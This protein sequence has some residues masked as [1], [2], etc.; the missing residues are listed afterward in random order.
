MISALSEV[1][2]CLR[3]RSTPLDPDEAKERSSELLD[4]AERCA[5]FVLGELRGKDGSLLRSWREGRATIGAYLED[6]AYLLEALL[7]LYE[8]TFKERWFVEA[9]Q[10][11]ETMIDRFADEER[12]GFFSTASDAQPLIARRKD[13]EDTP[14]PSGCS[15]AA[16]SLLRLA[17]LTG[18]S[19]YEQHALSTLS[20][21]HE[22]APRYPSA[23]GHLL[24]ALR[25][26]QSKLIEVAIVGRPGPD[27]DALVRVV[28]ERLRPNVVL[29][30]N[31]GGCTPT[32]VPLLQGREPI[33]GSPA[34]YVCEHF[35][36]KRPVTK[37]NEL[38]ELL[39]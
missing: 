2:A 21:L 12:G 23:F 1:G 26:E 17:A 11:A 27:R 32:A 24:Q 4:A 6:H 15:S 7:A 9:T 31:D 8:A 29:A 38:R 34:A 37:P 28:Q 3:Y 30:V 10:I 19:R 20:L 18:E 25:L 22:I 14:I 35:A 13:V 16:V 36:C 33:D 5:G 39:R